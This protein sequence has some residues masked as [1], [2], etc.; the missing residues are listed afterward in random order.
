MDNT[1]GLRGGLNASMHSTVSGGSVG[2][3]LYG[4]VAVSPPSLTTSPRDQGRLQTHC[5]FQTILSS[6]HIRKRMTYWVPEITPKLFRT[7]TAR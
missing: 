6:R 1:A 2:H 5:G 3:A 7:G 4:D